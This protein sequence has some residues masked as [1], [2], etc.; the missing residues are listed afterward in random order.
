MR[1]FQLI[2]ILI[3]LI[4]IAIVGVQNREL[5]LS[6]ESFNL[7]LGFYEFHSTGI[8]LGLF[9]A[10]SFFAGLFISFL[11]GL[12]ARFKAHKTIKGLNKTV[13]SQLDKISALE[14]EASVPL[15]EDKVVTK[16]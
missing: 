13:I 10:V 16:E 2:V 9:F 5:F 14:K 1:K 8:Q 7:N 11:F 12:L 3:I 6:P 4:F 15:A